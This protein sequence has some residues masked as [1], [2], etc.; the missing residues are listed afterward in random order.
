MMF[1][2]TPT[3]AHVEHPGD[4]RRRDDDG[5]RRLRRLRVSDKTFLVEPGLIP[6]IFDRPPFLSS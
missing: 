5:K 3:V 2:L 6:F 1:S 4:V